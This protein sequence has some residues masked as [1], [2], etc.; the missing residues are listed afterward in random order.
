MLDIL[1]DAGLDSVSTRRDLA[2]HERCTLGRLP[3]CDTGC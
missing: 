1:L 3:L 2:G